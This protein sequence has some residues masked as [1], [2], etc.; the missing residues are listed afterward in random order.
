LELA[1]EI[2]EARTIYALTHLSIAP[3]LLNADYA[4]V[5]RLARMMAEAD[6]P[7]ASMLAGVGLRDAGQQL[8]VQELFSH[9]ATAPM[10]MLLSAVPL[11]FRLATL[12]LQGTSEAVIIRAIDDVSLGLSGSPNQD[13]IVTALQGA[14]VGD[15]A[16]SELR[17]RGNDLVPRLND[18]A[19][20]MIYMIGLATR[21]PLAQ[22]LHDQVWLLQNGERLFASM[23]S[24]RRE[25]IYPFFV[26]FWTHAAS[27]E[28]HRFRTAEAYTR[29]SIESVDVRSIKGVKQLLTTMSFCLG[30]TMPKDLDDWLR[31][32]SE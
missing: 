3:A 30:V 6:V 17:R 2:P 19:A 24:I 28:T 31:S 14:L 20:G 1:A 25:L 10:A 11:A 18:T 22:A 13:I 29:R 26:A 16:L 32:G 27:V 15:I 4:K 8:Q 7:K 21:S 5:I 12:K 9:P 23:P